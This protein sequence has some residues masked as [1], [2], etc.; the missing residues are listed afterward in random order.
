MTSSHRQTTR[1]CPFGK[2]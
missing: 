2:P 1:S